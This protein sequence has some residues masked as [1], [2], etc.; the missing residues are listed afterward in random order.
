MIRFC[1]L[2]PL[3]LRS[4]GITRPIRSSSQAIL[5]L[6]LLLSEGR[7]VAT[8]ALINE[9]WGGDLPNRPDNALQAHISRLRTL[10]DSLEPDHSAS[11]L[12]SRSSGYLLHVADDEL[13]GHLF[14]AEVNALSGSRARLPPADAATRARRVLGMWRGPLFGGVAGGTICHSGAVRY[15][16]G[17]YRALEALFEAEL[18][19][20]N[21]VEIIPELSALVT[22]PAL[23]QARFC[24]QLMI[25]LYRSGRQADALEVFYRTRQRVSEIGIQPLARLKACTQ[26]IL[27]HNPVLLHGYTDDIILRLQKTR[28]E[29][30]TVYRVR[31]RQA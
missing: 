22:M 21:H 3:E 12:T 14:L 5:L 28:G 13:D 9:L 16:R 31:R 29:S 25:A 10:V 4:D 17:R 15:E 20:G 30:E 2:G 24:E 18:A 11:R 19:R 27:E 23:P 1:L 26:A 6:S 8:D 7:E